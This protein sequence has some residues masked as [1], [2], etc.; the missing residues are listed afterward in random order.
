M[1]APAC[2]A[3]ATGFRQRPAVTLSISARAWMLRA[4]TLA[5][6]VAL[7]FFGAR[8]AR[9]IVWQDVGQA[10]ADTPPHTLV[11]AMALAAASHV[12]YSGFDLL[13]RS[14]TGHPLRAAQVMRVT[15]ISYAFNLNLGSLVGGIALRLRLYARLGLSYL[16]IS[17]VVGLSIA[18]NWLGY[19][20]L[21]GLVFSLAPPQPPPTWTLSDLGLRVLGPVLLALA[22]SYMAACLT[23]ARRRLRLGRRVIRLPAPAIA[24]AQLALSCAN[25]ALMAALMYTLLQGQLPYAQVLGVLLVAAIAG[26]IAHVPA[27]L[28]VLEAV[29]VALLSHRLPEAQL[30][31][32][33]LTYRAVYYLGP[34]GLAAVLYLAQEVRPADTRRSPVPTP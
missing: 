27:G 14:Y 20:V 25:W 10:L 33:L 11:A 26:V 30:L 1:V 32:A 19:L 28:G 24:I 21:A 29:F 8:Y 18:T 15:F 31:A 16:T 3:P 23:G 17:R 5:F 7:A 22:A 6:F 9:T 13:G 4:L 12:T 2:A 34:L